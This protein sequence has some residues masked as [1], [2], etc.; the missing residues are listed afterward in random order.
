MA[1]S[2][3]TVGTSIMEQPLPSSWQKWVPILDWP[4][5]DEK[6]ATLT[7]PYDPDGKKPYEKAMPAKYYPFT[8]FKI[9]ADFSTSA[10]DITAVDFTALS[11]ALPMAITIMMT[12]GTPSA[13]QMF[14][15]S[16]KSSG[17][18]G[19]TPIRAFPVSPRVGYSIGNHF[20]HQAY[21]W[22]DL[23]GLGVAVNF[24]VN[25][26]AV[27]G[28]GGTEY[29]TNCRLKTT[30]LQ[31]GLAESVRFIYSTPAE[32]KPAVATSLFIKI[33]SSLLPPSDIAIKAFTGE[34]FT[35][36]SS[37]S[38]VD[39]NIKEYTVVNLT[40]QWEVEVTLAPDEEIYAKAGDFFKFEKAMIVEDPA[41]IHE[42]D[43]SFEK[44]NRTTSLQS[45][46][47]K[48]EFTPLPPTPVVV[49]TPTTET[50]PATTVPV[51]TEVIEPASLIFTKK[52]MGGD[53][54]CA[55]NLIGQFVV[56]GEDY[57]EIV[58]HPRANIVEILTKSKT[59]GTSLGNS[60]FQG[61][62]IQQKMWLTNEYYF[63]G[64]DSYGS[65]D[66]FCEGAVTELVTSKTATGTTI[67]W[68]TNSG[69]RRDA[70]LSQVEANRWGVKTLGKRYLKNLDIP[71]SNGIKVA[72]K[73][74]TGWKINHSQSK[75]TY[76]VKSSDSTLPITIVEAPV[77]GLPYRLKIT[78]HISDYVEGAMKKGD[79]VYL[80]F[81][82]PYPV[83]VTTKEASTF[84]YFT[85]TRGLFPGGRWAAIVNGY[86][87]CGY[88]RMESPVQPGTV[89]SIVS[90]G[91]GTD[92]FKLPLY[93]ASTKSRASSISAVYDR[94]PVPMDMVFCSGTQDNLLI[95][96]RGTL[97]WKE[98]I[99]K[100]LVTLGLGGYVSG[101][102][103]TPSEAYYVKEIGFKGLAKNS[104]YWL[105]LNDGYSAFPYFSNTITGR[106]G[107]STPFSRRSSIPEDPT[108]NIN[109]P[110][111]YYSSGG[112]DKDGKDNSSGKVVSTAYY[113]ASV[114]GTPKLEVATE[115]KMKTIVN[116]STLS[117]APT[118]PLDY[119]KYARRREVIQDAGIH[120]VHYL[121]SG[122]MYLIYGATCSEMAGVG[123]TSS[124][125]GDK[126]NFPSAPC[127]FMII[128][129]D[130]GK[131]WGAAHL[132]APVSTAAPSASVTA[133]D[134]GK[135]KDWGTPL[136]V[137]YD[138]EY[139]GSVVDNKGGSIWIFGYVY[140][141]DHDGAQDYMYLA[142]YRFFLN[143]ISRGKDTTSNIKKLYTVNGSDFIWLRHTGVNTDYGKK[144]IYL[145][146]GGTGGVSSSGSSVIGGG[147]T[148][149][150]IYG[151]K[152]L[153]DK[154]AI[155]GLYDGNGPLFTY[156]DVISVSF[157][158]KLSLYMNRR[159]KGLV[160][161]TSS[162]DSQS[163]TGPSDGVDPVV[164]L[165]SAL[166]PLSHLNKYLF[167]FT[168]E[169][170]RVKKLGVESTKDEIQTVASDVLPQR[171]AATS[172]SKGNTRVFF[173]TK[174]NILTC[175]KTH[176]G[177]NTWSP[178]TNW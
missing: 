52:I 10:L 82:E 78:A 131:T 152:M 59:T 120:D 18:A 141:T 174:N 15:R 76:S 28:Y 162:A 104:S 100:N 87:D 171:V 154:V 80:L 110:L 130:K 116:G 164:K 177:G 126:A 24:M 2:Y 60:A 123:A 135:I 33:H 119:K 173:M 57:Y 159:D 108:P 66:G 84:S 64:S 133:E 153:A 166:C 13:M 125:A 128:S 45:R 89:V 160:N 169:T 27:F 14:W 149:T 140:L 23:S 113:R 55:H 158:G 72:F 148:L 124:T 74:F 165:S 170:L 129:K 161:F 58:G 67:T 70:T 127:V 176:D 73:K 109:L 46:R 117:P 94:W 142:S 69:E 50:T 36:Y 163:W 77:E 41:L 88:R 99:T 79:R 31:H 83:T 138:F 150:R 40:E 151:G 102:D 81:D 20:K 114:S 137:L 68:Y 38:G 3:S 136:M 143:Q 147:D 85:A 92:A 1:Y 98:L 96:R 37:A 139:A 43:L 29:C 25:W 16:H 93:L 111:E 63:G 145:S 105:V 95:M 48:D 103:S 155:P 44:E 75:K 5:T 39:I 122:D 106:G 156:G 167:Y 51:V 11:A 49:T 12:M 178:T 30:F 71:S 6:G 97:E 115:D 172:D 34:K 22:V 35:L 90:I 132:L 112:V 65:V 86:Y 19:N 91:T 168:D 9:G 144:S 61:E 17:L 101:K 32:G 8:D 146:T 118:I 121:P 56:W 53:N 47:I 107:V 134:E 21:F 62:I 175:Y 54:G 26:L 7:G 157:D 42:Y 4:T